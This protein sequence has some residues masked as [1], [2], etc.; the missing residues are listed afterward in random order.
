MQ[1]LGHQMHVQ[2]LCREIPATWSGLEGEGGEVSAGFPGVQGGLQPS[3]RQCAKL[4]T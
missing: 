2:A 1:K 4:E 3:P